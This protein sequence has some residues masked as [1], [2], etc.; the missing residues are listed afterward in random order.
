M[1]IMTFCFDWCLVTAGFH[2]FGS[3]GFGISFFVFLSFLIRGSWGSLRL[4]QSHSLRSH[5]ANQYKILYECYSLLND[6]Q[7]KRRQRCFKH[8]HSQSSFPRSSRGEQPE[9]STSRLLPPQELN[10]QR[11][12][13]KQTRATNFR[14]YHQP[15]KCHAK[16]SSHRSRR[17]DPTSSRHQ[18]NMAPPPSLTL[19]H[20]LHEL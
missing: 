12:Y 2:G 4:R 5:L 19:R 15:L 1:I 18:T 9:P 7:L 8:L 6:E 16:S 20:R 3:T 11:S 13:N 14:A 17:S 10:D